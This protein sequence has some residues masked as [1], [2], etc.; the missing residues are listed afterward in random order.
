MELIK[1]YN[2][3]KDLNGV[4]ENKVLENIINEI[5]IDLLKA[6]CNDFNQKQRISFCLNYSKKLS[7]KNRPILAYTCNDQI[8]NYQIFTDCQILVCLAEDDKLPIKDYKEI[9]ELKGASYP[10]CLQI[11]NTSKINNDITFKCNVGLLLNALKVHKVV[12]LINTKT[13]YNYTFEYE[14]FKRFIN[15][16]NINKSDNITLLGG[17]NFYS[18]CKKNNGTLGIIMGVKSNDDNKTFTE[19][20]LQA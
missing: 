12:N 2:E 3:L 17:N 13:D 7:T 15:F 16:M 4:L 8:E 6:K 14:N 11:V 19:E 10:N 20:D 1:I 9:K 18:V 5:E